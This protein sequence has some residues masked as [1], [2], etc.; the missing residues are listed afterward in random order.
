MSWLSPRGYALG[1]MLRRIGAQPLAFA[2][3][4]FAAGGAL[5]VPV[6]CAA[7]A[8]QHWPLPLRLAVEPEISVF[9]TPGTVGTDI[10][11][12]TGRLS[13]LPSVAEVRLVPRDVALAELT[14]RGGTENA[15]SELKINPLPD[16]LV[17]RLR[18]GTSADAIDEFAAGIRKWPRVDAVAADVA[19]YRKWTQWR[20][21][22]FAATIALAGI[23]VVVLFWVIVSAVRLQAAADRDEVR[24]LQLVGADA[25]FVRRPYVY[26]GAA[27]TGLAMALAAGAAAAVIRALGPEITALASLYGTSLKWGQPS[28][29]Y[30]GLVVAGSAVIGGAVAALGVRHR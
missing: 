2:F 8:V 15:A 22:V 6:L 27:T 24:V 30:F 26:L 21:L 7:V 16:V 4:V 10:K 29:A 25:R 11:S 9:V 17:A 3:S 13:A 5:F 18:E 23:G 12:L 1:R 20:R 19:W 28:M 14:S